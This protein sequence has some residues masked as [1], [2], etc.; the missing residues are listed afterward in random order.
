MSTVQ[1]L[2]NLSLTLAGRLGAGRTAGA[3]ESQVVFGIANALLDSWST[4][5]LAVYSIVL[6]TYPLVAGTESYTIGAG[7]V[8]NTTRPVM[9]Q[10][11]DIVYTIE[12]VTG[13]SPLTIVGADD[14]TAIQRLGD[15]SVLP[16]KLYNDGAFPLS[17]LFL[18][19]IPATATHLDLYTWQAFAQFATLA[20]TVVF[21]PGYYRAI[22]Y[23][24]AMEV[25]AAFGLKVPESVAVIALSSKGSIEAINGRLIPEGELDRETAPPDRPARQ[26]K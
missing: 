5:R 8:F 1:D 4:E 17:K 23:N 20:D 19:P 25:A 3:A 22:S 10:S 18:Y 14:W 26:G 24:L 13:H 21:P 7:G 15:Q 2:V 9:V 11:A 12:G 16:R 6:A